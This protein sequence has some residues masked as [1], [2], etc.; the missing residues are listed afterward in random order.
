MTATLRRLLPLVLCPLALAPLGA[1][2]ARAQAADAPPPASESPGKALAAD[3]PTT[4]ARGNPFIAPADWRLRTDGDLVVLEAPEGDSWLAFF[5]VPEA[6]AADADAA[7]AAAWR[8]YAPSQQRPLEVSVERP[9]RD[10]WTRQKSYQYRTSPNEKRTVGGMA[11]FAGGVWTVVLFDLADATAE[12]RGAQLGTALGRLLPK[13]QARESFAGKRA[14]PLDA[15]RIGELSRFVETGM[16]KL[17][18][19]GVAVGLV[20]DGSVVFAGGFGER[21]LG[22]GG[23]VDADTLF[24]IASNTKA[25]T[26]LLLAKLVES[27]RATWETPVTELLPGFRLG[28][29]ATTEQVQ[30]RHLICACTGMPRQD[31]EMLLE[32]GGLTPGGAMEVL[33][34]MQPTTGFGELFQYSNAMA[35]AAGYAAGHELHPELEFGAAYDRAIQEMVFDPLGMAA[36]TFDFAKALANPNHAAVHG[37]ELDFTAAPAVMEVNYAVVPHRPAGGAWSNVRDM[38]RYVRMELA[39]GVLPEGERYI[40]AEPLL[41]RRTKKVALGTDA[42][43]GMGLMV[44]ATYQV[45]VV[46]HGGDLIG[47]HS[48]MYWLPE[49]GV[50]AVILTNGDGGPALRGSFQ[51]KLLE[52]LF[53]GR[54]EA[55]S[56]VAAA[57]KSI[58]ASLE[59]LRGQIVRPADARA[60]AALAAGY[61]NA[62]LGSIAVSR[63]GVLTR[64]DFGEWSSEVASKANPDG[65]ISFVTVAP[66]VAGFEFVVGKSEAGQR[67]LVTRDAQHEYL[68]EER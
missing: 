60:S 29:A 61:R 9:D 27:G 59:A 64:F 24:M 21:E 68:F 4:T 16:A 2:R 13:G 50:G 31:F 34:G 8:A 14:N 3:T 33:A 18:I 30:V 26:T 11:R 39:G 51:R 48:E 19:P 38:L 37:F 44:D 58:L 52:V 47:H 15:A 53:D 35:S 40:A 63:D 10:G 55:D 6:A 54:P 56:R 32:F 42:H 36:T 1:A 49:H 22:R 17:R 23:A 41:A 25:L 12:K 67:T 43:Y 57:E 5:D 45:E 28:D 66:G 20:Q 65:T 62:A 7:V 46:H